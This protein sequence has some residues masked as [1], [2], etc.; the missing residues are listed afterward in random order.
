MLTAGDIVQDVQVELGRK[1]DTAVVTE[2]RLL[3][4]VGAAQRAIIAANPTLD[5]CSKVDKSSFTTVADQN[6]YDFSSVEGGLG[7]IITLKYMD[8]YSPRTLSP[9]PGG[10]V[11]LDNHVPDIADYGSSIPEFY[12]R[13]DKTIILFPQPQYSDIPL[14]LWYS[15]SPADPVSGDNLILQ[16]FYQALTQITAGYALRLEVNEKPQ[17]SGVSELYISQGMALAAE[18]AS[19]QD[20]YDVEL[21][22]L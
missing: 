4:F 6:E 1:Y 16:D 13:R 19:Q 15:I 9:F 10:A 3:R 18:I 5:G 11:L 17:L 22:F 2:A 21:S 8:S 12:A 14:H 7:K 20:E